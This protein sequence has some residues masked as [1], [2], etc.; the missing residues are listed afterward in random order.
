MEIVS[1]DN[2]FIL[3]LFMCS[4][5]WACI[6]SKENIF[7]AYNIL[8]SYKKQWNL[9]HFEWMQFGLNYWHNCMNS[10]FTETTTLSFQIFI[11]LKYLIFYLRNDIHKPNCFL[12]WILL[13][14]NYTISHFTNF[15][16]EQFTFSIYCF[17][18]YDIFIKIQSDT[19]VGS[20]I[21]C[22]NRWSRLCI[23]KIVANALFYMVDLFAKFLCCLVCGQ[24]LN[25]FS[26]NQYS[27]RC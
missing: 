19:V 6:H 17:G 24:C 1:I 12:F 20:Y 2:Y 8:H 23:T 26:L 16:F 10:T 5:Y 18:F 13:Q 4:C 3:C 25:H 22:V 7:M 9:F 11:F 15:G 14:T 21:F 27:K